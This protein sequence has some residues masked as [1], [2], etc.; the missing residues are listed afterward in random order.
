MW[1]ELVLWPLQLSFFF[2]CARED[3]AMTDN[4]EHYGAVLGICNPLLDISVN[5][6]DDLFTKYEVITRFAKPKRP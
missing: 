4:G 1:H 3:R 6:E 2:R 5:A